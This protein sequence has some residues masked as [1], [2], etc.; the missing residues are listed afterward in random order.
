MMCEHEHFG[1]QKATM[2]VRLSTRWTEHLRNLP[3]SGMGYQ[4]V[5]VRLRDGRTLKHVLALNAERLEIQDEVELKPD[6]IVEITVE[7]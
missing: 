2:L 1:H 6:E 3:E 5:T 7:R 4:R